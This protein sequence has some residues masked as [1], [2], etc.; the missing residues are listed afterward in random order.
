MTISASVSVTMTVEVH[1]GSWSGKES[2][3]GLRDQAIREAKN[4]L[5]R[6]VG[7]AGVHITDGP[8]ALRVTMKGETK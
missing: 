4:K 5:T 7:A 2:F 3:E 6:I 1:V 8:V